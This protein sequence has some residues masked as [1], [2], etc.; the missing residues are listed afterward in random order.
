VKPITV[1]DLLQAEEYERVRQEFR[2]RVI[3]LKQWRRIAVGDLITL[4]F[5]NRDTVLFQIQ[6][7][8]RTE[9]IF[10]PERIR[11]EV[12]I[13]NGQIPGD[14]ELSATLLIEVTDAAQVKTVLDRLQG[15]D[16]GRTVGIRV[17]PHLV[18]GTFEQGRSNEEKISAVHYVRFPISEAVRRAMEDPGIP[19]Q[20][21]VT[22][23]RYQAAQTVPEGMRRS[24]LSD[25]LPKSP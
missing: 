25:L 17:E 24:L 20:V 7:M 9:R 10:A 3:N 8:L 6:E 15:I 14:G 21:V 13:Y 19:M 1:Q 11:E 23:P 12:E 5:E 18:Y 2:Q 22:H 16:R 4:V